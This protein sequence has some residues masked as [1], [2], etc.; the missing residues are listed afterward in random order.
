[1]GKLWKTIAV[2]T[3]ERAADE[4]SSHNNQMSFW[5]SS[6]GEESLEIWG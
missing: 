2:F 6:F 5:M 1:M 3:L 4:L